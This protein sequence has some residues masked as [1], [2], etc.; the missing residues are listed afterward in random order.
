MNASSVLT[1]FAFFILLSIVC[2]IGIIVCTVL[3]KKEEQKDGRVK[4][5]STV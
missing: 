1:A 4:E 5:R 2:W 3:E